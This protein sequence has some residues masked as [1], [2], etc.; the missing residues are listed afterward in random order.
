MSRY[1]HYREED[2]V[3]LGNLSYS[4]VRPED[5][6]AQDVRKRNFTTAVKQAMGTGVQMSEEEVN[7]N[8]FTGVKLIMTPGIT[9]DMHGLIEKVRKLFPDTKQT[10]EGNVTLLL[11]PKLA[12]RDQNHAN[13]LFV[14]T[15]FFFLFLFC[16]KLL[17]I[18]KPER[19]PFPPFPL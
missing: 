6:A 19:Y 12:K 8:E 15:G 9:F 17:N 3:P 2:R 16:W 1:I 14:L 10:Q 13:L 5:E 18:A 11:I 4:T 7:Y